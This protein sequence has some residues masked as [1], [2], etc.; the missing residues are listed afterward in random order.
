MHKRGH[1]RAIPV[2]AGSLYHTVEHL[3]TAGPIALVETNRESRRPERTIYR[4]TQAGIKP[5]L[6]IKVERHEPNP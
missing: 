5:N 2:K 4:L 6:G 1:Q 3:V